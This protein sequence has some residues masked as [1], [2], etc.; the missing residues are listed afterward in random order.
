MRYMLFII[1]CMV[2]FTVTRA[3]DN[4]VLKSSRVHI[5]FMS[6][7]PAE[8]IESNNYTS[9]CVI[10][11]LTGNV[12]ITVPMQS[13]EFEKELMQKHFNN[14]N[15][16]NTKRYPKSVFR[17]KIINADSTNFTTTGQYSVV[18]EGE[19][20]I[21]GITNILKEKAIFIISDNKIMVTT[22]FDVRLSDYGIVFK[23]G[24]PATNVA[25]VIS[26]LMNAE[27]DLSR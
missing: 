25:K 27:F 20:T 19:M 4:S 12:L 13:F 22:R 1:F 7:T 6:T 10:D 11:T 23:K 24:K 3:A 21:K 26:I 5:K 18:V 16:L 2:C 8:Y 9:T 17:A 15:F 14:R